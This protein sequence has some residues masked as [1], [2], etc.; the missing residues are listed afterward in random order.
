MLRK[1]TGL[2]VVLSAFVAL[3]LPAGALA[4]NCTSSSAVCIY[5]EQGLGADG[6]HAIG[7]G[8]TKPLPVPTHVS[9]TIS[10]SKA[11][12]KNAPALQALVSN[13]GFGATRSLT[14][15][16]SGAV[17]P[18]SALNA[19]FDLGAGPIALIAVLAGTALLLLV[20]TGWRGW[21]RWRGGRLAA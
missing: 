4:D 21:R 16:P 8:P 7:S 2:L 19:V 20:G 6:G 11:G 12:K 14:A 9:E 17:V 10:K 5:S 1:L 13:P 15:V 3:A 18:P